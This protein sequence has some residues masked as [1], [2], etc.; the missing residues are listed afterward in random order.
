MSS[1][2]DLGYVDLVI[3]VYF[4]NEQ[5]PAGGAMTQYIENLKIGEKLTFVG[6]KGRILSK[7]NGNFTITSP[8][9]KKEDI[10]GSKKS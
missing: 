8:M 6:P 3:K 4:A 9:G 7:R 10:S 1:D 2:D 5:F